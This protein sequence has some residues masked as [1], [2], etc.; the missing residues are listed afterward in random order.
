[1]KSLLLLM[2]LGGASYVAH[3]QTDAQHK[4]DTTTQ[5]PY[6]NKVDNLYRQ[7]ED[8][9][10]IKP[11]DIPQE[12][13]TTLKQ[14]RYQGWEQGSLTRS[15]DGKVYELHM[16]KGKKMKVYRFDGQGKLVND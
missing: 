6:E 14:S 11:E 2:A 4:G 3:A 8:M 13:K 10:E 9:V 15:S 7:Q 5:A 16:N 1:M 12:L